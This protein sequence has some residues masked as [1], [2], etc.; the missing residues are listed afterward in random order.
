MKII[1]VFAVF[2]LLVLGYSFYAHASNTSNSNN[3]LDAY[4]QY[5]PFFIGVFLNCLNFLQLPFWTGW[6]LYLINENY[7]YTE[8]NL[9]FYFVFGTAAGIFFGMLG[10]IVFLNSISIEKMPFT[11]YIMPVFIPLFFVFMAFY[12]A[13]KVYKKYLKRKHK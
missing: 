9:K 12:Q 3:S 11:K 6:N 7:I 10:L 5:S 1:D 2:F 8:K 4:L 13:F